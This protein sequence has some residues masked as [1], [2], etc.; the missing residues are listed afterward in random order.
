LVETLLKDKVKT[1][2]KKKNKDATC[3]S[4]TSEK[5]EKYEKRY[6]ISSSE[7]GLPF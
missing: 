6:E 5:I 4:A 7:P 3:R 1:E 2:M